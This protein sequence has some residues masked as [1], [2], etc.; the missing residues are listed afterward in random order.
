MRAVVPIHASLAGGDETYKLY[1]GRTSYFNPRLP[2]GRRPQWFFAML[3]LLHFNPRLPR[4]RRLVVC[5]TYMPVNYFN[6]RLPRGRR[7]QRLGAVAEHVQFQSTPPSREATL[8]SLR[9][10]S[11]A[12][13]QSTPPSREATGTGTRRRKQSLISIHASL[14]GG[15]PCPSPRRGPQNNFNPRLPRGRRL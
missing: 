9:P 4:G 8:M 5:N 1:G 6:P 15:D 7:L 13:F 14:A 3:S 12:E 10:V 2:R 11:M